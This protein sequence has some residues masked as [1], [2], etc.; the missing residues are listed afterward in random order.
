L[1]HN[2]LTSIDTL[3]NLRSLDDLRLR[4]TRLTQAPTWLDQLAPSLTTLDLAGC[5][6]T[7]IESLAPLT[8]LQHVALQQNALRS[9]SAIAN[10][11]AL[12]Y[13]EACFCCQRLCWEK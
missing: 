2:S 1:S 13:L 7:S 3:S 10:C 5:Q 9:V 4:K 6:L 8:R 12:S 11:R